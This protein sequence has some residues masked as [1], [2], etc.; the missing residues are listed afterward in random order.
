[1]IEMLMAYKERFN[2]TI[3]Q[4]L[5]NAFA[6]EARI[7]ILIVPAGVQQ[8]FMVATVKGF[9]IN[10]RAAAGSIFGVP[11]NDPLAGFRPSGRLHLA[12]ELF[13]IIPS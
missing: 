5:I 4:H 3:F 1:M 2:L 10:Q 9:H 13:R 11:G 12:D 6:F 8:E 7:H